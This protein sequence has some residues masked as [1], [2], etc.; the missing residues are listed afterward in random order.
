MMCLHDLPRIVSVIGFVS[1]STAEIPCNRV[2]S[3]Y[4]DEE[5]CTLEA[6][7]YRPVGS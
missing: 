1:R 4:G 6:H 5:I 7:D 3:W 2:A